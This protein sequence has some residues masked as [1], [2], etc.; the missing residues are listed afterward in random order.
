MDM[1]GG[2]NHLSKEDVTENYVSEL[3]IIRR[4][5]TPHLARQYRYQGTHI[6]VPPNRATTERK[7]RRLMQM[8][9]GGKIIMVIAMRYGKIDQKIMVAASFPSQFEP[10][11]PPQRRARATPV[12][13]HPHSNICWFIMCLK[14]LQR[15]FDI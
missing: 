14:T 13:W 11:R 12:P 7:D 3:F 9:P 8:R 1:L 6:R 10:Q 5:L 2:P 4:A 15:H